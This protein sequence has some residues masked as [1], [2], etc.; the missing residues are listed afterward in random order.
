MTNIIICIATITLC[1]S[2]ISKNVIRH[3]K[4]FFL[5]INYYSL[6]VVWFVNVRRLEDGL[7]HGQVIYYDSYTLNFSIQ[8]TCTLGFCIVFIQ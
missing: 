7:K 2:E 3:N 6:A 1:K 8:G 4:H 5:F